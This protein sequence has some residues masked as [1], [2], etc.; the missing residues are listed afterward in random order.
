M[1]ISVEQSITSANDAIAARVRD[2][3]RAKGIFCLNLIS[4]PGSGKTAL[5]EQT[6]LRLSGLLRMA[7]VEGD[8]HTDLDSDRVRAAGVAAVQINTLGG[9]HLDAAMIRKALTGLDLDRLDLLIIENVGNLLCPAPW[10]L[11]EEL[12]VVMTSLPE[13]ADKPLKYPEAFLAARAL[14]IN[15]IDLQP[16]LKTRAEDIRNNALLINPRLEIFELS[17]ETG[18]GLD[19]WCDWLRRIQRERT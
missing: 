10:N 16:L 19:G 6:V 2:E 18:Q 1:K 3:L 14:L 8:P 4:A 9:C 15:K 7:V 13:G 11:G 12:R 17:C 5:I